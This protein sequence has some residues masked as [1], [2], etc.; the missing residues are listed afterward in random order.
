MRTK[1]FI[2]Y[3]S[4]AV[5]LAVTTQVAQADEVATQTPS[6]TEGNQYQPAPGAE[7]FGGEAALPVTPSST[8]SAPAASSEV[9]KASAPA[10]ST[11]PASQSSE[12]AT[13]TA[14]TSVTSSVVSSES[15]TASTSA[16]NS[17]TSNS[18]V[19]TPAKLTNSTDVPSPTLKVQP[20]DF[21]RCQQP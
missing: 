18:T 14:L 13:A 17:E 16:T 1:D 21:Y 19:A 2:Y 5:L 12:A 6:V 3:T 15:A 7:I 20:T 4:A 11:S 8:V 9:A 10:V